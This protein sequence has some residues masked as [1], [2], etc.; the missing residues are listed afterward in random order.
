MPRNHVAFGASIAALLAIFVTA[1]L[2]GGLVFPAD[3]AV[4]RQFQAWRTQSPGLTQAMIALTHLGSIY[5]TMGGGLLVAL[6]LGFNGQRRRGFV[7]ALTV[8]GERLTVDGIKLLI[9]RARPA[10]DVHPVVTHS[11]S[12][13]SGHAANSM[14]V[15]LT[16]ALV[17]VPQPHRRAAVAV[18]LTM[19]FLIGISRCY[20]GV[21]WPSDVIAGWALGG[22][23]ALV[24]ARIANREA[25]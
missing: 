3:V 20:L 16:I 15:F 18:A 21:H 1:G 23:V 17:A 5:A 7:L 10:F 24:A 6:W 11:A 4:I 25:R 12:F 13:P 19:S 2:V 9:D 22:A 14:A 8:I